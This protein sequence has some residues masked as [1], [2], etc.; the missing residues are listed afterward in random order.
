MSSAALTD[1]E[2]S[3]AEDSAADGS[4]RKPTKKRGAS[5]NRKS[6]GDK[7][8]CL[9]MDRIEVFLRETRCACGQDCLLKVYDKGV[10]GQDVIREL[11]TA[12]FASKCL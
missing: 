8:L 2:N 1:H 12:R 11:R 10:P 6:Y 7:L 3:G 5:R 4:Q 9:E